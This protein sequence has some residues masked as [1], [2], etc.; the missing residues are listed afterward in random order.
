MGLF[1]VNQP[2]GFQHNY[3]YYD[4]RKEKIQK[5]EERAKRELGLLP[6]KEFDPEDIRGK[7]VGATTHLKRRKEKGGRHL[8]SGVIIMLIVILCLLLRY[9]TTGN[10]F[11]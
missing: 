6:E 1:K 8:A 4:P 10:L 5:I 3:M 9:L 11:Y 7:F 2:R